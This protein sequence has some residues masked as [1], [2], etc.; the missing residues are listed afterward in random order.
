MQVQ[1]PSIW[2]MDLSTDRLLR[3]FEIPESTVEQGQGLASITIDT[4]KGCDK[5][6]AY[7]PDLVN[8]QLYVYR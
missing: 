7:I 4:D 3:R 5:S 6:F 1:K 2:I 8:N